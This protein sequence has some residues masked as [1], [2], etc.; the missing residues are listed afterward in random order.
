MLGRLPRLIGIEECERTSD[1][2]PENEWRGTAAVVARV[3]MSAGRG[4]YGQH[5][6]WLAY[7]S[8]RPS[9]LGQRAFISATRVEQCI[10]HFDNYH[11]LNVVDDLRMCHYLKVARLIPRRS[12]C[13]RAGSSLCFSRPVAVRPQWLE[14]TAGRSRCSFTSQG[15]E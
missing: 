1:G 13:P 10:K 15:D 3:R 2:K 7:I 4:F 6:C 8:L 14:P 9:A 12:R 11:M 5:V